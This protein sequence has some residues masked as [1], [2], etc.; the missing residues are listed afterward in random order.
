MWP[1]GAALLPEE[2]AIDEPEDEDETD[3]MTPGDLWYLLSSLKPGPAQP[4]RILLA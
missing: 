2:D 4:Q 1:H 3:P